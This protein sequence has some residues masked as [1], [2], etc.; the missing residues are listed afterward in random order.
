MLPK[1]LLT[2]LLKKYPNKN[3]DSFFISSNEN[4]SF[5]YFEKNKI[6]YYLLYQ[7]YLIIKT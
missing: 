6:I 3:W 7:D 2:Y 1:N 4:I 5:E